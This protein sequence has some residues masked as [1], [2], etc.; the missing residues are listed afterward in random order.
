MT[1]SEL[2]AKLEALKIEHGD[3]DVRFADKREQAWAD[4]VVV[5]FE[6][7]EDEDESYIVIYDGDL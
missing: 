5:D 1:I 6:E 4:I 7:D 3:I 2:V